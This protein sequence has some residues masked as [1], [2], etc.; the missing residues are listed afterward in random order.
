MSRDATLKKNCIAVKNSMSGADLAY[1]IYRVQPTLAAGYK[2]EDVKDADFD[3]HHV[4]KLTSFQGRIDIGY[5]D[6]MK[7]F[8]EGARCAGL[9]CT[10][11]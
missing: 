2:K 7:A 10:V 6:D 11:S 5:T 8:S 9:E 1:K 4:C 3:A